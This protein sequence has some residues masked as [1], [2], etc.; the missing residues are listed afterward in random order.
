MLVVYKVKFY[1][2][3][4]FYVL[5]SCINGTS[6]G[7]QKRCPCFYTVKTRFRRI[8]RN[9]PSYELTPSNTLLLILSNYY[10][11]IKGLFR[12]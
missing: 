12:V 2:F 4:N 3:S 10:R 9:P 8:L 6:T 7:S 5:R 1:I 11:D